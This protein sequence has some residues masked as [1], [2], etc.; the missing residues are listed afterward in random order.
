MKK[1]ILLIAALA[2]LSGCVTLQPNN[3]CDRI[4]DPIEWWACMGG[5]G[6]D[7]MDSPA[8]ES[9]PEPEPEQDEPDT[10]CRD[11]LT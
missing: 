8:P 11:S 9:T 6:S 7:P 10:P 3:I 2:L 1:V 5:Y 4:T